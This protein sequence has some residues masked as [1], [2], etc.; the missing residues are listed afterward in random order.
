MSRG[1][2][3]LLIVSL[4]AQS[5]SFVSKPIVIDDQDLVVRWQEAL[6]EFEKLAFPER[7]YVVK[8]LESIVK[9]N[10]T[11]QQCSRSLDVLKNG[12][13]WHKKFA[14]EFIESSFV[15]TNQFSFG[16]VSSLGHKDRCLS[17]VANDLSSGQ[18]GGRYCIAEAMLPR[19]Q[20]DSILHR[21]VVNV[22]HDRDSLSAVYAENVNYFNNY[23]FSFGICVPSSCSREDVLAVM[24]HTVKTSLQLRLSPKCISHFDRK[25]HSTQFYFCCVIL[26][27][28]IVVTTAATIVP[29]DNVWLKIWSLKPGWASLEHRPLTEREKRLV[30]VEFSKTAF[31]LCSVVA[32]AVIPTM[33][34]P[35]RHA[36][37][38]YTLGEGSFHWRYWVHNFARLHYGPQQATTFSALTT[39]LTMYPQVVKMK[40]QLA[41][42]PFVIKRLIRMLPVVGTVIMFTLVLSEVLENPVNRQLIITETCKTNLWPTLFMINNF[43]EKITD[44]VS[45][46]EMIA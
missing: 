36:I 4:I 31:Q 9:S 42:I 11:S 26:A 40:G 24:D 41:F 5:R 34:L 44:N 7:D 32:H 27:L 29:T 39:T 18:F 16:H 19:V 38:N 25:Q 43:N 20:V 21:N 17:I 6:E 1:L 14:Y 35:I 30:G 46:V 15:R 13:K 3:V 10:I 22:S 12:F 33:E 45:T 28:I 23:G 37:F 8:Q 2:L